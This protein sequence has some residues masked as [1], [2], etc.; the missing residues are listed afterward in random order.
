MIAAACIVVPLLLAALRQW[1][2]DQPAIAP[3]T[4]ALTFALVWMLPW[5]GDDLGGWLLVDPL[6]VHVA[7]L[8]GFAWLMAS[9]A[10]ALEG[11]AGNLFTPA[12]VG[13]INLALLADS[14][15]LTVVAASGAGLAAVVGVSRT[16]PLLLLVAIGLGLA[17]FG[18]ACLALG[19]APVAGWAAQSWSGLAT[20]QIGGSASALG[21]GVTVTALGLA[22]ATL[23]LPLWAGLTNVA[24]PRALTML[25]GP[26]AAVWLVSILRLRGVLDGNSHAL[27]PGGL[28]VAVGGALLLTASLCVRGQASTGRVPASLIALCGAVLAGFGLGGA[29]ATAGSLLYLTLG[30]LALTAAGTGSWPAV[31]GQA[32]LAGLPPLGVFAAAL[33]LLSEAAG[34]GWLFFVAG[35]AL[36]LL[37]VAM[38]LRQL[39]RMLPGGPAVPVGWAGLAVTLL[40]SWAMP[41]G[42]VAWLQ[43]IAASAR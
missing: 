18:V 24:L 27:A 43:G 39:P 31:L 12:M 41:S 25:S 29:A 32:A 7:L 28:L 11:A 22:C 9:L 8:T 33:P 13:L 40:A 16:G 3:A 30:C 19:L 42:A 6:A 37:F 17:V 34:R 5:L 23:A 38:S 14:A 21:V 20:A 1:L 4:A 15:M 35:S 26:L 10:D 36:W 2:P